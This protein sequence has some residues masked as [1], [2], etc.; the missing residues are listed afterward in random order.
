MLHCAGILAFE[1]LLRKC[2]AMMSPMMSTCKAQRQV[3]DVVL[4]A[5]RSRQPVGPVAP[6]V[7][8][9]CCWVAGLTRL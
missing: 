1:V 2:T 6:L 8:A 9:S 5:R 7:V 4:Q 3:Q